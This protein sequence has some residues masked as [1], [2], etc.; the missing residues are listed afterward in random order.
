MK[1]KSGAH[2]LP[3]VTYW[4][5][6]KLQLKIDFFRQTRFYLNLGLKDFIRSKKSNTKRKY[7]LKNQ[8]FSKVE[9][10]TF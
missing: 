7:Y 8:R 3:K 5:G 1:S 9:K 10:W 2:L 6:W 4:P